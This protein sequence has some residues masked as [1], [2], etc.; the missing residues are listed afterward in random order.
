MNEVK[1]LTRKELAHKFHVTPKTIKRWTQQGL[2]KAV[3]V[4]ARTIRYEDA[5]VLRLV[6]EAT[7]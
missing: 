3:R 6:R 7:V 2:L 1:L 4:S 5:E